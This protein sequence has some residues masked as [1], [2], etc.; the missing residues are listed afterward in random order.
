M[1]DCIP[2]EQVAEAI[3]NEFRRVPWMQRSYPDM[4]NDMAQAAIDALG[5]TEETGPMLTGH[6]EGT[7]HGGIVPGRRWVSAWSEVDQ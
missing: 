2:T 6:F 7:N 5:L 1:T 3:A 4:F